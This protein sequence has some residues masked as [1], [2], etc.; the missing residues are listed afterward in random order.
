MRTLVE[1]NEETLRSFSRL[2]ALSRKLGE[3]GDLRFGGRI[4]E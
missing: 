4:D 3:D 2:L 1:E